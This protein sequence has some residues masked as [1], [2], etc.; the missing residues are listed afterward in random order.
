MPY[1]PTGRAQPYWARTVTLLAL[2]AALA[3]AV[4]YGAA[5]LFSPGD[6][7]LPREVY[8][9]SYPVVAPGWLEPTVTP[10][11]PDTGRR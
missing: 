11:P 10:G 8:Q 6:V 9:P 4:A 3:V 7:E 1:N 2:G 5:R